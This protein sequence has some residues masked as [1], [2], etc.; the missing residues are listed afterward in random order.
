MAFRVAVTKPEK[1]RGSSAPHDFTKAT[2]QREHKSIV[3]LHLIATGKR[4]YRLSCYACTTAGT[5]VSLT[6]KSL[7]SPSPRALQ[8]SSLI[9]RQIKATVATSATGLSGHLL[10]QGYRGTYSHRDIG[11][12]YC[13]RDIGALTVTGLSGHF[14]TTLTEV[15]PC[16]FLNC[17]ANARV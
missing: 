2:N 11:G 17:K 1:P 14:S 16:F 15:C 6:S 9:S 4:G 13:H 12:T 7:P 10:S 5:L 8:P 3:I